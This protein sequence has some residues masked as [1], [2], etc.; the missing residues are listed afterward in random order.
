MSCR[1]GCCERPATDVPAVLARRPGLASLTHRVG[2]HGTFLASMV[3][4]LSSRPVTRPHDEVSSWLLAAAD[5]P[6]PAGLVRRLRTSTDPAV[7]FLWDQMDDDARAAI[8]VG[9]D[10]AAEL[11]DR[12]NAVLRGPSIHREER[13]ATRLI[14]RRAR[15][16][17]DADRSPTEQVQLNRLL[18]EAA[19]GHH[20]RPS[21]TV[22]PLDRL[23]TRDPGDF[24]IALLDGWATVADVVSFYQERLVDEGYLRTATERRSVLEL[25]RLIGYEPRP[26]VAASVYLAFTLQDG[27]EV[28]IPAGT[29]VK[30]TPDP[31]GLPQ[32]FETADPL[33]ARAEWNVLTPRRSRPQRITAGN[34][35]LLDRLYLAGTATGL[36]RN[37]VLLLVFGPQRQV[38]RRVETV[39]EDA[40]ADRTLVRLQPQAPSPH[41]GY[42]GTVIQVLQR[43]RDLDAFGLTSGATT[44]AVFE[45]LQ[46]LEELASAGDQTGLSVAA[47]LALP[48]LEDQ[49]RSAIERGHTRIAPWL[50]SL[51]D[52][53]QEA[54]STLFPGSAAPARTAMGSG[55]AVTS[56]AASESRAAVAS[57]GAAASH[58]AVTGDKVG[59]AAEAVSALDAFKLLQLGGPLAVPRTVQP[60]NSSRLPLDLGT[61][62]AESGDLRPKLLA[63][64]QPAYA[65]VLYQALAGAQVLPEQPVEVFAFRLQASLYGHNA[66]QR[67]S[68]IDPR[69]GEVRATGDPEAA[70]SSDVIDLAQA[71]DGILPSS[72]VV[73]RRPDLDDEGDVVAGTHELTVALAGDPDPG[74]GRAD[75][76]VSSTVTRIRLLDPVDPTRTIDWFPRDQGVS[77]STIRATRVFA[78]AERL[79]LAE[80]P[81]LA[82]EMPASGRKDDLRPV[83]GDRIELDGLLQGLEP[84]RWLIVSGERSD[85]LGVEGVEASELVMLAGVD[86][87]ADPT[88]LGEK[89]HTFLTLAGTAASGAGGLSYAY[90]RDSVRIHG[91]VV[92]ATHGETVRQTLGSGNGAETFQ[93]FALGRPPLTHVSA[94][95]PAGATPEVE[96]RVN[97]LRWE[98]RSNL[99]GSEGSDRAFVIQTDDDTITTV[100]F[101][102]GRHGARL[103]SGAENVTA[104]Y[105]TG[106]GRDGNV[107]AGRIDTLIDRPL[108]A[109]DVVNPIEASGGADRENRDRARANAPLAVM[110]LD[111]LVSV[112]DYADFT[113]T[114]AG[115]DKADA[116]LLTNGRRRVLHLTVALAGDAPLDRNGELYRNLRGALTRFGDPALELRIDGRERRLT[117]LSAKVRITADERWEQVEPRVRSALDAALGFER[118]AIGRG[119]AR[120]E[121]STA[122]HEV[123]GVEYVDVDVFNWVDEAR[124]L[125][126]D[127]DNGTVDYDEF[128]E[129]TG[130]SASPPDP[131]LANLAVLEAPRAHLDDGG[132]IVPGTLVYAEPSI[133]DTI[134]LEELPR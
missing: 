133:R 81:I 119:V 117:L 18:V 107:A 102:D 106:L 58:G 36:S 92:K 98:L 38:L 121:A 124:I 46:E 87:A 60:A 14:D 78:Q 111:R 4:Q 130:A 105:R 13:F 84:G 134:V 120:S 1:C 94:P 27:H 25:A 11:V 2:V 42:I 74:V 97:D 100:V 62:L 34:A 91:N 37:D 116:Q 88:R 50:T 26:G 8:D 17:L 128:V 125:G 33:P 77:F 126:V 6:D 112:R 114:F 22:R 41:E 72:W 129:R 47:D 45:R 56:R 57:R 123:R 131:R 54:R 30:S 108:G 15:E 43:H 55:T 16:L 3:A 21:R 52:E 132:R 101:G 20:V 89:L 31:G 66:P 5:L 90:R 96:V 71:V 61:A 118:S 68:R 44:R 86:H 75:Y 28:E 64:V 29:L 19:L 24:T 76:G 49:R 113:R 51:I 122:I 82:D 9:D 109:K 53:L 110:A 127:G 70:E 85:I 99:V 32:S 115:I 40:D 59:R 35:E 80:E 67:P 10:L 63:T 79:E 69:T 95:T 73:V 23:T 12:L 104:T 103:P 83:A 93:R 48:L 39:V 65:P 7:A